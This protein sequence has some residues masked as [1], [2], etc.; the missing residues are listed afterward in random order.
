MRDA[1]FWLTEATELIRFKPDKQAVWEEL[2]DHIQCRKEAL[3]HDFPELTP[4]EA[5]ARA[6]AAMGDPEP[7]AR[8]LA[9]LHRPWMGYLW[10]VSQALA[11]L[12]AAVLIVGLPAYHFIRG[13]DGLLSHFAYLVS[14]EAE[15]HYPKLGGAE[16]LETVS[17]H[18]GDRARPGGYTVSVRRATL[19]RW[20]SETTAFGTLKLEL[21]I[22]SWRGESMA[23]PEAVSR[24]TD[25]LGTEY[26]QGSLTP[27]WV[28]YSSAEW[29]D[30]APLGQRA[31]L[32]LFSVP[33]DAQWVELTFGR[34]DK[35]DT[36][37]VDLT[38][39]A[40]L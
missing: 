31:A 29:G 11:V 33:E 35:T 25:D 17:C 34:G 37:R 5:E 4:E 20:K 24:V 10:R 40:E 21:S 32:M 28:F 38:G 3:L 8:D 12:A 16:L 19:E 9:R 14:W 27:G 39:E 23:L 13:H 15:D 7:L 6:V 22:H 26:I 2:S 1:W 18:A 30:L 36:L